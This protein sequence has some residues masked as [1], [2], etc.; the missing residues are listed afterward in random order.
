MNIKN[1]IKNEAID[2]PKTTRTSKKLEIPKDFVDG[3]K[4]ELKTRPKGVAI[5]GSILKEL[6]GWKLKP[7]TTKATYLA[8]KLNEQYPLDNDKVWKV[9]SHNNNEYYSFQYKKRE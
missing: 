5:P 3:I 2:I 6:F 7:K 8:T 4:N 9:S 1:I